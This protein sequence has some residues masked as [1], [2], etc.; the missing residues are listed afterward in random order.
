[1]GLINNQVYLENNHDILKQYE[2]LKIDLA[3]KYSD[4]RKMYTK[5]KNDFIINTLKNTN[6]R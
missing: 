6:N 5:N 4:N 1:M 2:K 3:N